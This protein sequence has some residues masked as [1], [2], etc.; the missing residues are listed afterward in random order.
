VEALEPRQLLTLSLTAAGRAAGFGLSTFATGFPEQSGHVGPWGMAFPARG[1]VLVSDA[2]GNVRLFPSDT[3]G[4]DAATVPPVSGALAP[5]GPAGMARVGPNVYLMMTGPNQVVQLNDT[6]TVRRVV[7]SVPS[8]LG[9]AVDPLDGH[10]FVSSFNSKI[11][12]VNPVNG[13]VS[14]FLDLGADGLDF[15]PSAGILY[16]A[17]Y[18]RVRGF[19]I[20]TKAMVFDS[21]TIAGGPDGIAL[22]TG[23]VAGD[24][25]ANTNGGTVV[26]VNLATA[27][28]TII[29]SGGS[30]GDFVSVDS[31]N[32]TLL[33]TQ[34]DRIMR[35]IPG[36]F[37]IPPY[38]LKTT[39]TL[40]V[41]PGTSNFGQTVT[42]TA[43]VA[44]AATGIPTGTV[45]FMVD[46]QAQAPVPLTEVG[47]LDQATFTT[48][49][50]MPGTRSITATYSGDPTFASSGS[51][52]VTATINAPPMI[53]AE[54]VV[55]MRQR[56]KK[57]K[58]VGKPVLVGFALD[59]ST[60]MN[61]ATVRLPANYQV[62][63]ATQKKHILVNEPVVVQP[64]YDPSTNV[65]TLTIVGNKPRFSKGGQI[66][67]ISTPP[68]GI[69]GTTG[70]F[71]PADETVFIILPKAIAVWPSGRVE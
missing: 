2:V 16:A 25:F 32:G 33:V 51:N 1:G 55:R 61:A 22:G 58:L 3:D 49:T 40:D 42:L 41:T 47:G 50:L 45:T 34:S 64:T 62:T 67:V 36:V 37:V 56:N 53:V 70:G 65:V 13:T 9:V 27:A 5:V 21:G 8:P 43:I 11:Y 48:S 28:Q 19:N 52:P 59:Y 29:A 7:A 23:P 26:E 17:T 15:D 18:G 31:N 35:L 39:T 30:R 38:L 10:L 12:D 14:V 46:G 66:K 63:F 20:T 57:G 6:G 54:Q 4:Q 24:L 44:T 69:T 71:L 68:T 60:A